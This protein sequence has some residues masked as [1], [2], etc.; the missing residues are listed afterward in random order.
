MFVVY[1][2]FKHSIARYDGGSKSPI[3]KRRLK[4]SCR[5]LLLYHFVDVDFLFVLDAEDVE[6]GRQGRCIDGEL[7]CGGDEGLEE[8]A[9][10]GEEGYV[11]G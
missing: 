1:D 10:L 4:D 6:G 2:A 9:G 3:R 11:A 8:C 7:G 5:Y